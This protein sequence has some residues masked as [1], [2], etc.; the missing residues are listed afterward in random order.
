MDIN[1]FY[2]YEYVEMILSLHL[3]PKALESEP[4]F[5]LISANRQKL[6]KS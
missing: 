3:P 5:Q 2:K 4:L 1:H 6:L